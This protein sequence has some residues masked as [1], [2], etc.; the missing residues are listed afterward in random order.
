M[1]VE[2]RI[3]I[4]TGAA[5]GI[6]FSIAE[7]FAQNGDQPIIADL[8][9][10][11][12]QEAASILEQKYSCRAAAYELNVA[13][14][15]S[16]EAFVR[17]VVDKWGRIDIVVNNAGLQHIDPVEHFPV[18]KWD[19]LMNVMLKGPFLMAKYTIPHMKRQQYGRIINISSVHGKLASPYKSAY[20]AAKHGVIGLTR[21]VALEVADHNIT[22]NAV[23]PGVVHTLL[24][25]DQLQKLAN[26][27]GTTREEALNKHLLAKQAIKRF[28][29]PEEVAACCIFLASEGAACITGD[30][31]SV[32][33]GW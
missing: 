1:S 29:K 9:L 6:G 22:V 7:A 17:R 12:A 15:R 24:I 31:I 33:G 26:E 14:A 10:D 32:S 13:N 30:S 21:T 8:S 16:V 11:N 25:D 3:A 18:E 23:L 28:V 27:D 5:R 2:K 4:V 20:V 19:L